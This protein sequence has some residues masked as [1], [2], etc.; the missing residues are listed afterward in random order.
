MVWDVD[1][2]ITTFDGKIVDNFV[3]FNPEAK[4]KESKHITGSHGPT[5]YQHKHRE[6]KW[7]LKVTSGS[8]ILSRANELDKSKD[9]FQITFQTPDE[10]VNCID[11]VVDEVVEGE[12][13]DEAPTYEIKGLALKNDRE[14]L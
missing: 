13:K 9:I 8:S 14:F 3:S 1:D 7:S 10:V 5:G 4:S 11:C 2:V 12:I 6:P